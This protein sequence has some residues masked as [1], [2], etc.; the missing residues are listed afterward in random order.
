[1]CSEG[2]FAGD[3]GNGQNIRIGL[4]MWLPMQMSFRIVSPLPDTFKSDPVSWLI[5]GTLVKWR[6][7]YS[8][9]IFIPHEVDLICELPFGN[10]SMDNKLIWNWDKEGQFFIRSAYYIALNIRQ[11]KQNISPSQSLH[12][13]ANFGIQMPMQ[14]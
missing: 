2:V 1:M 11:R 3:V 6:E 5:D 13:H 9:L 10:L 14:R 12:R 7:E 4:D 8:A